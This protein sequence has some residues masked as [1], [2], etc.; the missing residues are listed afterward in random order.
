MKIL[1]TALIVLNIM[2]AVLTYVLLKAGA[3]EVNPI[4]WGL[5]YIG[6]WWAYLYKVVLVGGGSI[7]LWHYRDIPWIEGVTLLLVTFYGVTV[8]WELMAL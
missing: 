6:L 5:M 1:L 2:D 3:T 8:M 4:M 7:V